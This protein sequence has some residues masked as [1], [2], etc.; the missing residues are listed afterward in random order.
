MLQDVRIVGLVRLFAARRTA[1]IEHRPL[2][3]HVTEVATSSGLDFGMDDPGK[4]VEVAFFGAK[5][6]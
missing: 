1:N 2:V 6:S 4:I 5:C 3:C